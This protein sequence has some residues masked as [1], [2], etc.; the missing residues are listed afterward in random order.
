MK[1]LI[2]FLS[3]SF[4]SRPESKFVLIDRNL[5]QP[6]AY[7]DSYSFDR[8]I[9]KTFPV[10]KEDL[11]AVI[12]AAEK[13]ARRIDQGITCSQYDTIN[14]NHTRF[15]IYSDC[16]KNKTVSVKIITKIEQNV[17]CAFELIKQQDNNRKA[18]RQL[19]DFSTYLANE[20]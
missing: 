10:Y 9:H 4:F 12:D 8:A 3:L 1:L 19:L 15:I 11:P 16:E 20:Q 2:L 13:A 6:M 5:K 14:A 17:V 18:Q 7:A